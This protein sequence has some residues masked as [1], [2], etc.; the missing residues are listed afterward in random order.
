[1][2]LRRRQFAVLDGCLTANGNRLQNCLRQGRTE[3][4]EETRNRNWFSILAAGEKMI[5]PSKSNDAA[6][7][8][9]DRCRKFDDLFSFEV[10]ANRRRQQHQRVLHAVMSFA[11]NEFPVIHLSCNAACPMRPHRIIAWS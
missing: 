7:K 6:L 2:I 9:I 11:I 3:R 4:L 5:K 10:P 8:S 1:M